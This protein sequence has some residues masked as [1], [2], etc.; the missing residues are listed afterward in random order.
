MN[1]FTE[2]PARRKVLI[3][4]GGHGMW[5]R[6]DF[7]GHTRLVFLYIREGGGMPQVMLEACE[8]CLK[9]QIVRY[10]LLALCGELDLAVM[11]PC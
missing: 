9:G 3:R 6:C 10:E 4:T 11:E 1:W 5:G 2:R 7:C 8:H